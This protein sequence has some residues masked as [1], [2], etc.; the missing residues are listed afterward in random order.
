MV[1][2]YRHYFKSEADG[3]RISVLTI[4]PDMPPYRGILQIVH[5]MSEYKER[6]EPFMEYM[7]ER[8]Y[9]TV[10]HDHRGHGQ[11]VR[12]GDDLGY[13]Y[14]GGAEAVLKDIQTVNSGIRKKFPDLPLILMG[15]SMGSL[16]VR[17]FAAAH[18]DCMN[19]LIVCGSQATEKRKSSGLHWQEQKEVFWGSATEANC[20]SFCPLADMRRNS[21]ERKTE[22]RGYAQTRRFIRITQNP[23]SA[24]L[25]LRTTDILPCSSL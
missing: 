3:L 18:D 20:L 7:A 11:S 1:K 23:S 4:C 2:R 21:V 16:A 25:L 14:G 17:A 22:M 10:I 6:Y 15:H 12:S 9:M 5:G 8:G 13:M 24:A 19:M